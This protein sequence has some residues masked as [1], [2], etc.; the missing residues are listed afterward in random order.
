MLG[1][2]IFLDAGILKYNK[3]NIFF[4]LPTNA[5]HEILFQ[6]GHE[7]LEVQLN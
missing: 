7:I 2:T 6:G 3:L 4:L 5:W 1:L